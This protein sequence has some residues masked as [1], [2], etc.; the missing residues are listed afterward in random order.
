MYVHIYMQNTPFYSYLKGM[1]VCKILLSIAIFQV[2]YV[3]LS[4]NGFPEV[5]VTFCDIIVLLLFY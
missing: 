2:N 5:T 4:L 3:L 1:Q